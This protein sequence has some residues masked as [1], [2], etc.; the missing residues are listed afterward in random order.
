MVSLTISTGCLSVL[1]KTSCSQ[2]H[3]RMLNDCKTFEIKI[4]TF[5]GLVLKQ[6]L[7]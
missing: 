6:H 4:I 3:H 5:S 2:S 7:Q 1:M